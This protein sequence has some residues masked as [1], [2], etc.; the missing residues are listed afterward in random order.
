MLVG[1]AAASFATW[2]FT[3]RDH[4][5]NRMSDAGRGEVIFH[6]HPVV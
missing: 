4:V 5:A 2:W 3:R 1:V 6:N